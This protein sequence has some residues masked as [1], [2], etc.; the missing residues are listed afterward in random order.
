MNGQLANAID[1]TIEAIKKHKQA[2]IFLVAPCGA[3]YGFGVIFISPD[4]IRDVAPT[5]N[6]PLI[7]EQLIELLK[8]IDGKVAGGP[9]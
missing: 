6:G 3:S 7:V 9:V 1:A 8:Q 2:A 5:I 4:F